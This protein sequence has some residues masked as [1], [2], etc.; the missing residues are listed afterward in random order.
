MTGSCAR[1]EVFCFEG[2]EKFSGVA[3][4]NC[5]VQ[6][7]VTHQICDHVINCVA[8][9]KQLPDATAAFIQLEVYPFFDMKKERL[10]AN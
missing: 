6:I 2:G 3:Y 1:D 8:L 5:R 10:V 7:E 4:A 9:I